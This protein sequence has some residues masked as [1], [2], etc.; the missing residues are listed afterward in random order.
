ME[1]YTT[2]ITGLAWVFFKTVVFCDGGVVRAHL[3]KQSDVQ[4]PG[5]K[6]KV[7]A[8]FNGE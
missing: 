4:E 8:A 5:G 3:L 2:Q 1:H 7:A 6:E